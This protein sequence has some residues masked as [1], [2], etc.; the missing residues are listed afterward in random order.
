MPSTNDI[1]N[2][3]VIYRLR[4]EWTENERNFV[5]SQKCGRKMNDRKDFAFFS[6]CLIALVCCPVVWYETT[7]KKQRQSFV[8]FHSIFTKLVLDDLFSH[9]HYAFSIYCDVA[10]VPEQTSFFSLLLVRSFL[11][12]F[13]LFTHVVRCRQLCVLSKSADIRSVCSFLRLSFDKTFHVIA[14]Y[15]VENLFLLQ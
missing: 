5:G 10:W 8:I 11:F 3:H 12:S 15:S 9:S 13:R 2:F 4:H 7:T 6:S 14:L 1:N